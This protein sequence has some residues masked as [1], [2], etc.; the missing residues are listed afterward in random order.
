MKQSLSEE[1]VASQK[2]FNFA[3]NNAQVKRTEQVQ[4]PRPADQNTQ[5]V[6]EIQLKGKEVIS[7]RQ[8]NFTFG[9]QPGGLRNK[10]VKSVARQRQKKTPKTRVHGKYLQGSDRGKMGLASDRE[11]MEKGRAEQVTKEGAR[12]V[13]NVNVY[14]QMA[15]EQKM[16]NERQ[17]FG[18][19][20]SQGHSGKLLKT[21][22]FNVSSGQ[23][24]DPMFNFFKT[25]SKTTKETEIDRLGKFSNK[26]EYNRYKLKKIISSEAD[27]FDKSTNR[28]MYPN[29]KNNFSK[30][31][32]LIK[33]TKPTKGK[34][35]ELNQIRSC[36]KFVD[37][38]ADPT[39]TKNDFS[40]APFKRQTSISKTSKKTSEKIIFTSHRKETNSQTLIPIKP[41]KSKIQPKI[42]GDVDPLSMTLPPHSTQGFHYFVK[43]QPRHTANTSDSNYTSTHRNLQLNLGPNGPYQQKVSGNSQYSHVI[44]TSGNVEPRQLGKVRTKD[45]VNKSQRR[46]ANVKLIRKG[47]ISYSELTSPMRSPI[48]HVSNKKFNL[49][50]LGDHVVRN[51]KL[52]NTSN[53]KVHKKTES[54]NLEEFRNRKLLF[55]QSKTISERFKKMEIP[56]HKNP[57]FVKKIDSNNIKNLNI[58]QRG[59]M[60]QKEK[61]HIDYIPNNLKNSHHQ[62]VKSSNLRFQRSPNNDRKEQIHSNLIL[63]SR[64]FIKKS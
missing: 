34:N 29:P 41:K 32:V 53:Y 36:T 31:Q 48:K 24:T 28:Q 23:K 19:G 42:T 56:L 43:K 64:R 60:H 49:Y 2:Q 10:L 55:N 54:Q 57:I 5:K 63:N 16:R 15:S 21:K 6:F 7:N 45:R 17:Q 25:G 61:P 30:N 50:N 1:R 11:Q 35:L 38:F 39:Q 33:E 58:S 51:K 14:E 52:F 62:R 8:R 12:K 40:N 46:A 4:K 26:N 44:K 20:T 27:I 13:A 22:S 3:K 59:N 9:N 47:P 37:F 18:S